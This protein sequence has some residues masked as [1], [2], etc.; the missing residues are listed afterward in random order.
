MIFDKAQ[1]LFVCYMFLDY[2][3]VI[4]FIANKKLYFLQDKIS[5]LQL[6]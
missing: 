3:L 2:F 6:K 4:E 1:H 5:L